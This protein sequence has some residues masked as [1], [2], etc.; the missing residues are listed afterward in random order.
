MLH[1]FKNCYIFAEKYNTMDAVARTQTAFRLKDSLIIRLKHQA[2]KENRSLNNLV[3]ETLEKAV[4]R[5]IEF[6]TL[7][8]PEELEDF[9]KAWPSAGTSMPEGYQGKTAAEQAELDKK[10]L[11]DILWEKYAESAD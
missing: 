4:G 5:E 10:L 8:S 2:R 3:E 9:M 1:D 6:P 11:A 7:P